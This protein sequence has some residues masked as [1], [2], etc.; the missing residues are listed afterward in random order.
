MGGSGAGCR[1]HIGK[2]DAMMVTISIAMGMG[3]VGQCW[4]PVRISRTLPPKKLGS[5]TC[6]EPAVP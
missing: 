2:T 1:C 6:N 4:A 5:G 3:D